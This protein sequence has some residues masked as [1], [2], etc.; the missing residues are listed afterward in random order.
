MKNKLCVFFILCIGLS[1]YGQKV[2]VADKYFRD[3]AYLK[4]AE[5]YKEALKKED[6]SKHI[7]TRI[8]DC[9]YNNSNI[10]EAYFWY[11]KAIQKYNDLHPEHAYKYI[12]TLR[13][14]SNYEEANR[15]IRRF[16]ELQKDG[17]YTKGLESVNLE[18]F[19]ELSA[20]QDMRIRVKNLDSNSEFSDFGG[21]EIDG[22]LYF[23]SSRKSDETNQK[24]KLYTWNEEPFLNL[25]TSKINRVDSIISVSD[26]APLVSDNI[27]LVNEHEGVLTI[28]KDGSTMYFTRNNVSKRQRASYDKEGTSNLKIYSACLQNKQWSNIKE[29]PFNDDAFSTGH[30]ALS[31][32]EKTLFFV[33]DR[34]GGFGQTDIYKVAI[35]SDGTFG[36]VENLG[37]EINTAGREVFPFVAKDSMFYFSSDNRI[38][39]GLLDIFESTILKTAKDENIETKNI[40]APYNSGYDDFAYFINPETNTGYFSSNRIGGK[41][42][43]DIY[44]FDRYECKQTVNGNV[45][46]SRTAE[47][48]SEV[49]VQLI[50]EA[51][52]IMSTVV[53]SENG[54]YAF[55]NKIPC[56]KNFTLLATKKNYRSGN[57]QFS[58]STV[59][60]FVNTVDLY[61]TPLII[62]KEIVLN[63]IF[64]DFDKSNIRVD[65]AYELENLVSVMKDN[66]E[67]T[68]TIESHT[69][70]RGS[71]RYNMRLSQR[72]ADATKEYILS[73][74]IDPS[75][76]LKAIGFGESQLLNTCRRCTKKQHEENR[77]SVFLIQS[78]YL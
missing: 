71:D 19:Q 48:L 29:L 9:Y 23:A 32:D 51:G 17:K 53:S 45:Y 39:L 54:S 46:D 4:A 15:Y 60:G 33:S 1:T 50:D 57:K 67:M 63:P 40:G 6:S 42:G 41:G 47:P 68:I 36:N 72:R 24:R 62:G 8:G 66:P 7:L 26:I 28:T 20:T 65:A 76:I 77:R 56:S 30:P 37:N 70:N 14:M 38:N 5:L 74:G 43:D 11:H 34:E 18:K 52:K 78:N 49:T 64:F 12:Q 59:N 58:T 61:L 22:N 10:D 69:D 16:K 73:R 3:F 2:K 75:R 25:Y 27:N 44:A 35:N 21:F 55:E 31:P 13:S